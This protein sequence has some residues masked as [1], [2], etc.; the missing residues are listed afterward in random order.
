MN[1][2]I[3][4]VILL[5]G[6]VLSI[7]ASAQDVYL[8]AYKKFS[9]LS[10]DVD[11]I[12]FSEDSKIIGITDK[13]GNLALV[14]TES[15]SVLKK[16]EASGKIIFQEFLDKDKKFIAV[17]S[18]G[19]FAT[20]SL[21]SFEETKGPQTFPSPLYVTLDPNQVYLTVL[22]KNNQIEVFDL[23]AGMTQTRIQS[24][25]DLKNTLFLGF[26]RFGQQLAA[27][28]NVGETFSW[29][30]M[31]QKF[32]RELKLQSGE[33]SGSRS[34]IHS[35][36][37]SKGSDN[38]V[39]GMQ[40]VFI[41]KGGLQPGRQPERRNILVAYDWSTGQEKKRVPVR[42]RP[43]G[44]A[45]GPT[46]A[47]L[48]YYSSDT[49]NIFIVNLDK[50]EVNESVAVDERPSAIAL[51]DDGSMLAVGTVSGMVYLYEVIRNNP[52]EI[53]V[54]TPS[55]NRNYGEQL[56]KG[57]SVTI[58]GKIDGSDRMSQVMINDK[59]AD[60]NPD[61][62]FRGA[63]DL[64]P[65]KNRVRI[66]AQNTQSQTISKDLYLNSEPAQQ[67][68]STTDHASYNKRIALVIGNADYT[69]TS[70]LRN[71]LNDAKSMTA[72]LKELGFEVISVE[73]GS[74]EQI[75][76]AIY[77]FGD[78]IQD[79]D[80]S[81]FFYAGHGL[82]VDGTNYLV[83]VDADIQ[84][85]LDVKQKC[86]PLTGVSNTMEFA[87]DEGLN[88]II[89]DACRNN[90]FP[91]GKRGGAGLARVNAPSGTLIAYATDPGSVAS[92]GD[93]TNG[94]YTGE[95]IKQLKI[96]QRIEDIFMHTRNNVENLSAG[97][98]RPWEE[99]RLKGIFYLK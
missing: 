75:K 74:Y 80:V 41:P 22:E 10:G 99:A 90:P 52:A 44:V 39:V 26:D 36:S 65:G 56:V 66:A 15:S 9:G 38:F 40:E 51:S 4:I 14:E 85:H 37:A 48:F 53:R 63:V 35:A 47:T 50:G 7:S 79:V 11:N 23:K 34:V 91:A 1:A 98:Q 62:S 3:R 95:L 84:S 21:T 32:L 81:L 88:M 58:E 83:P 27:I 59:K 92:D 78:R 64:V 5:I 57:S 24:A 6:S 31:N 73:N 28:N 2:R 29:E 25:G 82:E 67:K 61:G 12:S 30:F 18:N 19:Q 46:P 89:L 54:I 17:R 94:L 70:K 13:K 72:T 20:Y 87:N 8:S 55:I 42:Y 86:I 77:A 68:N 76:N 49:R 69:S 60:L 43:D 96:S 16:I 71:T 45:M 33:Y 97:K 93:G